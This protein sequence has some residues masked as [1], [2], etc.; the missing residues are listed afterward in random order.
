MWCLL[1][2]RTSQLLATSPDC[3][4]TQPFHQNWLATFDT[5]LTNI[6]VWGLKSQ[7]RKTRIQQQKT[8]TDLKSVTARLPDMQRYDIKVF[9][10]FLTSHDPATSQ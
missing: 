8:P 2:F 5:D 6:F 1:G 3:N 10:D 4:A 7:R 9:R